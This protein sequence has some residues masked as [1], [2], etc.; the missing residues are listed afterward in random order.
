MSEVPEADARALVEHKST[1]DG[2]H[3]EHARQHPE[4]VTE[5]HWD[6]WK[7]NVPPKAP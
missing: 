1:F 6:F 2:G 4:G 7:A 3:F 5:E